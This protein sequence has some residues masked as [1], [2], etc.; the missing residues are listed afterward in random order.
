MGYITG[1]ADPVKVRAALA[2]RLPGYMVPAVVVMDALPLTVS[3]KLDTRA[4]PAPEYQD[5]DRYRAPATAVEQVLADIY[6]EVLGIERW[7]STTRSSTSAGTASCQCRSWRGRGRR[8][9]ICR[10]RDIFVEQT[11]ARLATVVKVSGGE[12]GAVDEGIGPVA[13]TRSCVGCTTSTARS[14]SSTRPWCCRPRPQ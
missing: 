14:T 1:I 5:H 8:G 7:A 11:V 3:G 12:A 6:A 4:L 13:A 10:P 9:L 2:D